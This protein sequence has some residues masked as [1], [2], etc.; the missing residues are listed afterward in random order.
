MP[1]HK[2]LFSS[3]KQRSIIFY[4][5]KTPTYVA[6]YSKRNAFC[7]RM[8]DT[9]QRM[10]IENEDRKVKMCGISGFG[11]LYVALDYKHQKCFSPVDFMQS[12][13]LGAAKI[14]SS[15]ARLHLYNGK[16]PFLIISVW[17]HEWTSEW[18]SKSVKKSHFAFFVG[19]FHTLCRQNAIY[20]MRIV[21]QIFSDV[22][23]VKFV[24]EVENELIIAYANVF[25][26][27]TLYSMS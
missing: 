4:Y 15:F 6:E 16:Y 27:H 23:S 25:S 14:S 3:H 10:S 21:S 8:V 7:N 12:L 18:A 13:W 11:C 24:I 26:L 20:R 22:L 1:F 19:S 9:K 2:R 5:S 17:A